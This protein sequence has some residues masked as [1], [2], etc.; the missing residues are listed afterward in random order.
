MFAF[1]C[2]AVR[3]KYVLKVPLSDERFFPK[4]ISEK[5]LEH[6]SEHIYPT[7]RM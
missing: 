7:D 2:I 5:L 1:L 6:F 3:G 4:F